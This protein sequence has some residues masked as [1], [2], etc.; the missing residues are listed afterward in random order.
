MHHDIRRFLES[1]PT[2]TEQGLACIPMTFAS[3]SPQKPGG[4]DGQKGKKN[5]REVSH[6]QIGANNSKQSEL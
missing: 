5:K 4:Q 1:E 2:D 3:D 6:A